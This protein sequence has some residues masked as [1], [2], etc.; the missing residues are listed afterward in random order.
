MA[1]LRLENVTHKYTEEVTAVSDVDW[2]IPD[3][4]AAG[5][6]G[7]SGCGKTTLMKIIAGLLKQTEGKVYFDDQEMSELTTQERNLCMVFQFPVVYTNMTIGGNMRFPLRNMGYPEGEIERKVREAAEVLGMTDILDKSGRGL[8]PGDKQ[9]VSLGRAIVRDSPNV[10]LL[11]EPLTDVEPER[12]LELR[13][14]LKVVQREMKSTMVYVTHDQTEALTFSDKIAI[15]RGGRLLQYASKDELFYNPAE[16]FVG[17]FIGSPGMNFFDC[18]MSEGGLDSGEFTL[19]ISEKVRAVLEEHDTKFTVGVRPELTEISA[20]KRG[21]WIP[22]RCDMVEFQ[23]NLDVF[24]LMK[25]EIQIMVSAP[26]GKFEVSK[27]DE[28]WIRFPAEHTRI[29]GRNGKL[30]T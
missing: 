19:K 24:S 1:N 2:S 26:I 13:R 10:I 25:G 30:L 5:L 6:L 22:F 29:Y 3:G 28:V 12:R 15:M 16:P 27:G 7:P 14:T 20:T 18:S 4:T 11:D 21:D 9:L 8:G 23:G 17:T